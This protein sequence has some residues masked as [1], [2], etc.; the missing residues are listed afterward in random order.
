MACSFL[1]PIKVSPRRLGDISTLCG[2]FI[3]E[4]LLSKYVAV[5]YLILVDGSLHC[6]EVVMGGGTFRFANFASHF[7]DKIHFHFLIH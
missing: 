5:K 1:K 7:K 4:P 3:P 2:R 6:G